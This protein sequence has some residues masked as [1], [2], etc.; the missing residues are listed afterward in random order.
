MLKQLVNHLR[1]LAFFILTLISFSTQAATITVTG[2]DDSIADDDI[3]SI[4]EAIRNANYDSQ[5]DND[6]CEAGLDADTILFDISGNTIYLDLVGSQENASA[7]GDF[8]IISDISILPESNIVFDS[9]FAGRGDPDR[10]FHIRVPQASLTIQNVTLQY[11]SAVAESGS[12]STGKAF[13]GCIYVDAGT[14][15][16]SDSTLQNCEANEVN[17]YGGAIAFDTIVEATIDNV[18]FK[19]NSAN[20]TVTT[21]G[22]SLGGALYADY[23]KNI[24]ITN[25]TFD[26]NS[27]S[28]ATSMGGAIFMQR[29]GNISIDSSTFK[30]NTTSATIGAGRGSAIT[31]YSATEAISI[32]N[33][34]FDSNE[35]LDPTSAR[36]GYGT[37]VVYNNAAEITIAN[38]TISNNIVNGGSNAQGGGVYVTSAI[39]TVYLYHNTIYNNSASNVVGT[40]ANGGGVYVGSGSTIHAENNLI[41]GNSVTIKS[42]GISTND[43]DCEGLITSQLAN[44]IQTN[45]CALS[46]GSAGSF[47]TLTE[48]GLLT[49]LADNGGQTETLALDTSNTTAQTLLIDQATCLES[50]DQDQ[51][52]F[53]RDEECDFGSYE[54]V[55]FYADSDGDGFGDPSTFNST[56]T[57]QPEG[58]VTDNR[59][60]DDSNADIHPDATELC[61]G[62]DN[63]CDGTI[64]TDATDKSTFYLDADGDGFGLESSTTL[65]CDLPS[66]YATT[67]GDCNDSDATLTTSCDV[68]D[69]IPESTES[70]DDATDD[71]TNNE[72][73]PETTS[74]GSASG[75]CVLNA[76]NQTSNALLLM[77]LM[78]LIPLALLRLRKN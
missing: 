23:T 46:A 61:D 67:F 41:A 10:I 8:D 19:S 5:L 57:S 44:A 29:G 6:D 11:G 31:S 26:S 13:G 70:S 69:T 7:T 43:N 28:Q 56:A 20:S 2:T 65:S 18:T 68:V 75:G 77:V 24:T 32:Q 48:S 30:S 63:N 38:N 72:A 73:N 39:E 33:S 35:V 58:Y 37:L 50:V 17:A 21:G 22:Y 52:G 60:C 76:N 40:N 74:S 49:P 64:D 4:R 53:D 51:R 15:H 1:L 78:S 47:V 55:I 16:L 62:T 12:A 42:S 34:T 36:N 3:C 71:T 27:T 45:L 25:S 9:S 14:L 66:G 59:D 54:Q